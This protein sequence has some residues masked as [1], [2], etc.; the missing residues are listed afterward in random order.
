V[1]KTESEKTEIRKTEI[2]VKRLT[3]AERAAVRDSLR[4]IAYPEIGYRSYLGQIET[5]RRRLAPIFADLVERQ[6]LSRSDRHRSGAIKLENL[7][8]DDGIEPPPVRGGSLKRI[9]KP[10]SIS[11]NVLILIASFFGQPYSMF[12]E[13][14]GLVNNL[15]PTQST[16][17]ELSGLGAASDLRFHIENSALRFLTGR[18]C[19]PKALLLTGVS[20]D[21]TPPYTRLSDARAAL[22]L[23]DDEDRR[24]LASPAYQIRLPYR[25]RRFRAGYDR[26]RTPWIPLARMTPEG[27]LVNAAFYGDMIADYAH[28]AAERAA[29]NFEAALEAVALDE[30]V[31]PGELLCIDNRVT[32][33]ARTPFQA[34]FDAEGRARRWVQRV[35]VTESLE[36]FQH[37][38]QTD[39]GVFAPTFAG[40][41]D[42][43]RQV[44]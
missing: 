24:L 2:H 22:E 29:R 17:T 36:N 32:L 38:D 28:P 16:S 26:I 34:S 43:L 1:T 21:V 6:D 10:G 30:V 19:A 39:D 3:D 27:L 31:E 7:P 25:W 23:L 13:G 37:W 8:R 35:F 42:D 33:H 5:A 14:Q 9:E 20:Q 12:C 44:G 11:E 18:D 41:P 40:A 4:D 15:V